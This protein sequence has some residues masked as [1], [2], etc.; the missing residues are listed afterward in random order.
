LDLM[1]LHTKVL[2][3]LTSEDQPQ[4]AQLLEFTNGQHQPQQW[5]QL[6]VHTAQPHH[7]LKIKVLTTL[8]ILNQLLALMS[9]IKPAMLFTLLQ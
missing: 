7:L 5:H 9:L 3:K 6:Q 2:K 8:N 1:V 4:M